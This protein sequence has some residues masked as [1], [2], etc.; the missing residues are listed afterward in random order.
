VRGVSH[1][2]TLVA[3]TLPFVRH[4]FSLVTAYRESGMAHGW[5]IGNVRGNSSMRIE[6]TPAAAGKFV[7][8]LCSVATPVTIPQPRS[9]QLSRFRFFL[10]LSLEAGR[11]RYTLYMGHFA[12][13][14][15]AE[16]WLTVLRHIYPDAFVSEVPPVKEGTLTDTQVLSVLE[17]RRAE[18]TVTEVDAPATARS[19]A[20]LRPEDTST[21]L[22]IKD[23]VA[24][25]APVWFAVQ[26]QWSAQPIDLEKAPQHAIFSSYTLYTMQARLEGRDWSCLRLGFFSDAISAKQVAQ[27]L[28]SEFPSVAVIPVNPVE[29]ATALETGRRSTRAALAAQPRQAPAPV[30]Q[31]TAAPP[32]RDLKGSPTAPSRAK[33]S[34]VT[35]EE[36]LETL[37]TSDFA[38]E[39]DEESAA[40]G[41]RHLQVVK[42]RPVVRQSRSSTPQRKL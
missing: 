5:H 2:K 42:E 11:K 14:A 21:R 32:P 40:T 35:L 7:I 34:G 13:L 19:I 27:Y 26:L 1:R 20:L 12:T 36:T 9:P 30:Q 16:K 29:H 24:R 39:G 18:G 41:V 8:S 33:R 15:E 17:E 6:S 10:G 37:R 3:E 22:A 31:A 4:L 38:M 23:A 28:Y 25:D